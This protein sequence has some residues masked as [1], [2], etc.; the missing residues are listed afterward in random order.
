[1][2]LIMR[3]CVCCNAPLEET[4]VAYRLHDIFHKWEANG[5]TFSRNTWDDYPDDIALT[6]CRC[7][8]CGYGVFTPITVGSDAFYMDITRDGYYL[9]DRWDFHVAIKALRFAKVKSVLD[10]GCGRGAFLKMLAKKLPDVECHGNDANSSIR[11]AFPKQAFLHVNL[12]DAPVGL[13]AVTLFQVIEH[14]ADPVGL[15][16]ESMS[17]VRS[18]GLVIVSVPDHTGPIRFFSDSH[19]AIPPHHVSVWTPTSMKLLLNRL[20]LKVLRQKWEPL[21]DYLMSA[22]LPMILSNMLLCSSHPGC[23]RVVRRFLANP[24]AEVCHKLKIK[25][26]PL[27]G[28]TYLV[29]AQKRSPP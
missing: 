6:L 10:V 18:G 24:V 5:I 22:Y 3:H 9:A 11:D 20:G 1:M 23:E 13:D 28:H 26:L 25:Y 29:V 17:K 7:K 27:R 8:E 12:P 19:T 2:A 14:V 15:I 21:P 16:Q 4:C